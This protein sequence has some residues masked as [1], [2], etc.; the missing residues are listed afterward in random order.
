M[1][2]FQLNMS[3]TKD[4]QFLVQFQKTHSIFTDVEKE[5]NNSM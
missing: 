4:V 5:E 1:Q 3:L 2:H